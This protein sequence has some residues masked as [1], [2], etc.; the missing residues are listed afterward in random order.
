MFGFD[1]LDFDQLILVLALIALIGWEVMNAYR[2]P[3]PLKVYRPTLFVGGVLSYYVLFA[4][5][6]A[7]AS[8]KGLGYRG[9]DHSDLVSPKIP[10]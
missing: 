1:L 4:P 5:L 9:L 6:Q 10:F 8:G 7:L 2:S 3:S